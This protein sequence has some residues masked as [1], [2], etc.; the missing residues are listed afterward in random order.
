MDQKKYYTLEEAA[1]ILGLTPADVNQRRER[2]ELRGFRDGASF[3]FKVEDVEAF[4]R[5]T[6]AAKKPAPAAEEGSDVLLSEAALGGSESTASGTVIGPPGKAPSDSDIR[7]AD[8][9]VGMDEGAKAAGAGG[10]DLVLDEA[11]LADDSE[12]SLDDDASGTVAGVASAVSRA[13]G[14]KPSPSADLGEAPKKLDDDDIV[15]GGS[16]SSGSDISIGADSGISLLDPTDSG[17]SLEEPLEVG[18][19]DEDSLELGED[20][21]LTFADDSV[22]TEAPTALKK[23]E[24]FLLTPLEEAAEE[25]SESGSQVIALDSP[26]AG[27]MTATM[28]APVGPAQPAGAG[29][30]AMLDEDFAAAGAPA[31][32]AVAPAGIAAPLGPAH[33]V[34]AEGMPLAGAGA[35]P[36]AL[37]QAPYTGL[38]IAALSACLVLLLLCGWLA[39]DLVRNMWSWNGSFPIHSGIMDAILGLFG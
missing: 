2:N 12:I 23:D 35:V 25:E 30:A 26:A 27:D 8:S 4:A 22:S 20:D 3:K 37:P 28:V 11:S 24:E 13:P 31:L 21:M 14:G 36:A 1:Q 38:N 33:P 32:A 6:R 10:S 15:L 7:L 34:F 18:K 39:F 5:Q 29:M 17:L 19:T 9:A 16:S